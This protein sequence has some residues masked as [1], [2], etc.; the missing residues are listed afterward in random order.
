[1]CW[2]AAPFLIPEDPKDK[3]KNE[4][5]AKSDA[6]ASGAAAGAGGSDGPVVP[7][8]LPPDVVASV[9]LSQLDRI[10]GESPINTQPASSDKPRKAYFINSQGY[11]LHA[12]GFG[13]DTE[14]RLMCRQISNP[15]QPLQQDETFDLKWFGNNRFAIR[16]TGMCGLR[17][18]LCFALHQPPV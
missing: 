17:A 6:G 1:M 2:C 11:R 16:H 5:D 14:R 13:Y 12:T 9:I 7:E 3:E 18:F 15:K 8:S 4:K 10:S